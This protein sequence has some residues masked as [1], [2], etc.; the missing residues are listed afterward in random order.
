MTTM[1]DAEA[2]EYYDDPAKRE[3]APGPPRRR[4]DALPTSSDDEHRRTKI[5]AEKFERA[6]ASAR[7]R[8][9]RAPTSILVSTPR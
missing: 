4:R 7:E 8:E 9:S 1:N 2:F 3:P 6:L 5:E